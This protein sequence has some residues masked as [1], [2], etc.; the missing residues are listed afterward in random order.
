MFTRNFSKHYKSFD[1]STSIIQCIDR[2][3]SIRNLIKASH[4]SIGQYLRYIKW[5]IYK[6]HT[7]LTGLFIIIRVHNVNAY[8]NILILFLFSHKGVKEKSRNTEEI[9]FGIG[10]LGMPLL[11]N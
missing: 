5:K 10:I 3:D 2:I 9:I 1:K 6:A 11:V 4:T 8:I 7:V